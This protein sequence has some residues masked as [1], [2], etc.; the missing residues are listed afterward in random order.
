MSNNQKSQSQAKLDAI[1]K[2]GEDSICE[3]KIRDTK[4]DATLFYLINGIDKDVRT[5]ACKE[6][7]KRALTDIYYGLN[8][9]ELV[10]QADLVNYINSLE[11]AVAPSKQWLFTTDA[12]VEAPVV[13]NK[14]S[15][16]NN[17]EI[18]KNN[19]STENIGTTTIT[20]TKELDTNNKILDTNTEIIEY[21]PIE[22]D[23]IES[24]TESNTEYDSEDVVEDS[25]YDI[26]SSSEVD[27]F[28]DED[29]PFF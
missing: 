11:N 17:E 9:T 20:E 8:E 16:K 5:E 7:L 10:K 24:N 13:S 21:N 4:T 18:I 28:D 23:V 12:S 19:T 2:Y 29:N 3:L 14:I 26:V 1:K 22:E 27:D 15:A 6:I 25:S